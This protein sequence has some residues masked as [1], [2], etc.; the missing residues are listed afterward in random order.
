[1]KYTELITLLT[2]L[3]LFNAMLVVSDRLNGILLGSLFCLDQ[4]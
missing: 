2:N 4:P 1:M 3:L